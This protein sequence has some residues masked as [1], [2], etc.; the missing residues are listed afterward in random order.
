MKS[1]FKIIC[2]LGEAS[3]LKLFVNFIIVAQE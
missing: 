3:L 2:M 1:K